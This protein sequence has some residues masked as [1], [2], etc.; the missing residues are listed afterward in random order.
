M[1]FPADYLFLDES[2]A[3][4]FLVYIYDTDEIAEYSIL[5][6]SVRTNITWY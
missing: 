2:S 1:F 6:V 5:G 3:S 4:I